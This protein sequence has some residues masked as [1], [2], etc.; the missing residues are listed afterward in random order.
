[1]TATVFRIIDP[2]DWREAQSRGRFEGSAD[3]A[4]DGFIHLST[5]EQV[6]GTHRKH[7]GGRPGLLLLE[8]DAA[9]LGAALRYEPSR[10]GALFPH[11]YGTLPVAA[12]TRVTPLGAERG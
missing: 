11:L 5:A 12:V 2:E 8:I 9:S 7:Y 10:G 3:D 4:R 6:L 1:M